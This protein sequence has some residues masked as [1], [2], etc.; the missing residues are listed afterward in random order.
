MKASRLFIPIVFSGLGATGSAQA[1]LIDLGNGIVRET[2][3]NLEWMKDANYANT[4]GY[5]TPAGRHVAA[6]DGAMTW[7][8]AQDWIDSL[9]TARH[10]G[11]DDWRLPYTAWPDPTC[12]TAVLGGW[13]NCT[14]S[15]LGY[16]FYIVGG[17]SAGQSMLDSA[18]LSGTFI[19]LE[20]TAYWSGT[21]NSDNTS[22]AWLFFVAL[23]KQNVGGKSTNSLP[24]WAVREG[25]ASPMPEPATLALLG[26]GLA[27]LASGRRRGGR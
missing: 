23:G 10:L 12:A 17:L 3:A 15:E 24:A 14:G 13:N 25:D 8:E 18:T 21:E 1:T 19:N 4:A 26:I 7:F 9:N 16:L 11:H 5:V 22:Q 20:N 6:S 27:G 2:S